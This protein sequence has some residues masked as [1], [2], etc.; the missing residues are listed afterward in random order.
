MSLMHCFH[1]NRQAGNYAFLESRDHC[2]HGRLG[3]A[4][5]YQ[6]VGERPLPTLVSDPNFSPLATGLSVNLT[7]SRGLSVTLPGLSVNQTGLSVTSIRLVPNMDFQT[8]RDDSPNMREVLQ[9][10][11]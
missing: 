9:Y 6:P 3:S 11:R 4:A 1:W 8:V 10:S 2:L 5:S 7:A